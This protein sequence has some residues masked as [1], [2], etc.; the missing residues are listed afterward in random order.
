MLK[1][2]L[3]QQLSRNRAELVKNPFGRFS[4]I[5]KKWNKDIAE[6]LNLFN[7]LS[8]YERQIDCIRDIEE[9]IYSSLEIPMERRSF[10]TLR[11]SGILNVKTTNATALQVLI[12]EE[13]EGKEPLILHSLSHRDRIVLDFHFI[14]EFYGFKKVI[15][16]NFPINPS[17]Q[18]FAE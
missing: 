10:I 8:I 1:K 12:I 2:E 17:V 3:K 7:R 18:F 4:E 5:Q 9:A 16:D 13:K 11:I 15:F 14:A 6:T